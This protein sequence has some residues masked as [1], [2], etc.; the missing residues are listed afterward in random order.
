MTG[1]ELIALIESNTNLD[2]DI[3]LYLDGQFVDI[4]EVDIKTDRD[5][6]DGDWDRSYGVII[7]E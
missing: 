6:Y 4:K 2:T 5:P 3:K 7:P 1:R